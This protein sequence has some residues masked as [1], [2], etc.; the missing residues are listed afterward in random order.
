MSHTPAKLE[1]VYSYIEIFRRDARLENNEKSEIP[2]TF[3]MQI[4][5]EKKIWWNLDYSL[6]Q[7]F[8]INRNHGNV[9]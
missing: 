3:S 5:G 9:E 2:A 8:C 1:C 4:V 7:C 6:I